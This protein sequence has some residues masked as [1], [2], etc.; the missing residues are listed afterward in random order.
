MSKAGVS[1]VSAKGGAVSCAGCGGSV[2][3]L[4]RMTLG[5]K[6]FHRGCAKC[7]HC[8][9]TLTLS[10]FAAANGNLFCKPHFLELFRSSGGSYAFATGDGGGGEAPSAAAA[11][12]AAPVV[13]AKPAASVGTSAASAP[14][15]PASTAN[16]LAAFL[17]GSAAAPAPAAAAPTPAPAAPAPTPVAAAAPAPTPTP[18][19]NRP[20]T[21][22][23]KLAMYSNEAVAKAEKELKSNPAAAKPAAAAAAKQSA[24][25]EL[26]K[27]DLP[28]PK[29]VASVKNVFEAKPA[30][31]QQQQQQPEHAKPAPTHVVETPKP[32]AAVAVAAA[33]PAPTQPKPKPQAPVAVSVAVSNSENIAPSVQ[34]VAAA[35]AAKSITTATTLTQQLPKDDANLRS[36]LQAAKDKIKELEAEVVTLRARVELADSGKEALVAEIMRLNAELA[37]KPMGVSSFMT[38]ASSSSAASTPHGS[39]KTASGLAVHRAAPSETDA[40]ATAKKLLKE[41]KI[42]KAEYAQVVKAAEE[43]SR[44]FTLAL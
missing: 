8:H 31:S 7:S 29:A 42:T 6:E 12:S 15:K 21:I 34:P 16:R 40:L 37:A 28:P 32:V 38:A 3:P 20:L 39:F 25:S 35:V 30:P 26:P 10:N 13:A 43:A 11:A 5:D 4:E 41:G 24:A 36:E 27:S 17:S 44:A 9:S 23:E 1:A 33:A 22:A 2:Y 14:A 19:A 18:S